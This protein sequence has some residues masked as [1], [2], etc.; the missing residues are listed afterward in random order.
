M[1]PAEHRRTATVAVVLAAATLVVAPG[2][3]DN[4]LA[5]SRY[6]KRMLVPART[7]GIIVV[8][9]DDSPEL[10]G[11]RLVIAPEALAADTVITVELRGRPVATSPAG[12]V[13][14]FGPAGTELRQAARLSLPIDAAATTASNRLTIEAEEEDGNAGRCPGTTRR[15]RPATVSSTPT[16]RAWPRSRSGG[17]SSSPAGPSLF[18]KVSR[19]SRSHGGSLHLYQGH[20]P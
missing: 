6:V 3:D 1:P 17:V 20:T 14:A 2:C 10:A 11:T 16:S 4:Q 7:G 18:L 19:P 8:G 9:A 13:V 5:A 12:P 15:S